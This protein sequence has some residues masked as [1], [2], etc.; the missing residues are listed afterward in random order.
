[1]K[2]IVLAKIRKY[3]AQVHDT[4]MKQTKYLN[5]PFNWLVTRSEI[6][7]DSLKLRPYAKKK[8]TNEHKTT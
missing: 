8:I 4:N 7:M 6:E 5:V 2:P 3:Y 1:M